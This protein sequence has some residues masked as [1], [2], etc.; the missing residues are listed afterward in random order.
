ME[1]VGMVLLNG[2]SFVVAVQSH[3]T[4]QKTVIGY[5]KRTNV[6]NADLFLKI[7]AS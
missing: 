1:K 7:D 5:K 6:R 2:T 3:F 4:T